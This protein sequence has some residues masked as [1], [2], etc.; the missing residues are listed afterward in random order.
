LYLFDGLISAPG[1]PPEFS[2]RLRLVHESP[3]RLQAMGYLS[4]VVKIFEFVPGAIVS[5][6]TRPGS[7][8][9]LKGQVKTPGGRQFA[10]RCS[11]VA[12]ASGAFELRAPYSMASEARVGFAEPPKL[13]SEGWS[14]EIGISEDDV[15][16]GRKIAWDEGEGRR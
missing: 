9:E 6:Q 8:V 7:P 14:V 4:S 5:G 15:I 12:D 16:S 10:Y 2:Q 11:T 1:Q 3:E 13:I